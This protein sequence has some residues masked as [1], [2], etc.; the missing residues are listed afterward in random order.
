MSP[1]KEVIKRRD[2]LQRLTNTNSTVR[3][4]RETLTYRENEALWRLKMRSKKV[5]FKNEVTFERDFLGQ[6]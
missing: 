3:R 1:E 2:G 6:K 5:D 4:R